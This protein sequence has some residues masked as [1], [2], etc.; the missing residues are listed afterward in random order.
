MRT[1]T[2]MTSKTCA[3]ATPNEQQLEHEIDQWQTVLDHAY[4][5]NKLTPVVVVDGYAVSLVV[6]NNQLAI[7]DGVGNHTRTRTIARSNRT[8]QRFVVLGRAGTLSLAAL[9]W[10]TEVGIS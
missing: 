10:C 9:R 4:G 1:A 3:P 2:S 5:T 7:R 6:K 8:V